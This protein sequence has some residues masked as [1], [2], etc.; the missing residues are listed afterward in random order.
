MNEWQQAN[1]LI[2]PDYKVTC[3]D[4]RLPLGVV[5]SIVP[6][7]FPFMV[8]MWT[9]PIALT[10]GNTM[11]LKPSEKVPLTMNRVVSL[12]IEA[13]LPPG[14]LNL[15]HG[16]GKWFLKS[17]PFWWSIPFMPFLIELLLQKYIAETATLLVD[18][19]DVK[20]VTFVGTSHVADLLE[21][22]GRALGKRVL[23]LGKQSY[24]HS[25]YHTRP[26]YKYLS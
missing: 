15:V 12:L 9:L 10:L 16:A 5:T 17:P 21:K 6:F 18:H 13:G 3:R 14:V 25:K 20:A 1:T 11:V 26:H 22:R 24:W 23:A 4:M 7:N 19:P 8:P 2:N